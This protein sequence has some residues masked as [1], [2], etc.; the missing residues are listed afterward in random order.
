M[1]SLYGLVLMVFVLNSVACNSTKS[2]VNMKSPE[3]VSMAFVQNVI[4]LEIKEA[5][6]I[7]MGKTKEMLGVIEQMMVD[8]MS[9]EDR[10][11]NLKA[12]EEELKT[13]KKTECD[14]T[15]DKAACKVC[16]DPDGGFSGEDVMLTK[17]KGKWYVDMPMPNKEEMPSVEED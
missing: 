10:K 5:Q 9:E 11:N 16:C 14:I 6:A 8:K 15:G 17:V 13:L 12:A 4:R 7:S 2:G 3:S 1:K